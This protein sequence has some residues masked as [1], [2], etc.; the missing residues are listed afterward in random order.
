MTK[1][2][3][4]LFVAPLALLTACGD[5]VDDVEAPAVDTAPMPASDAVTDTEVETSTVATK[6]DD[7]GDASGTYTLT[8]ADGKASDLTIDTKAGTYSYKATDGTEK[9][10]KY[11]RSDDGYRFIVG[12][13]NGRIAYFAFSEGDLIRLP[14]DRPLTA[15]MVVDGERYAR[16]GKPFSREPE[17]GSPVVPEDMTNQ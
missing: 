14:I 5:D 1:F 7:A 15:E 16:S 6:L 9:T 17:L 3:S 12:D 10:G 11:E 4:L 13:Y 2:K 8:G